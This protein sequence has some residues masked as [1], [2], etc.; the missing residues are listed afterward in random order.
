MSLVLDFVANFYEI[1]LSVWVYVLLG[2]LAAI[3][4]QLLIPKKK[5]V[6]ELGD[7]S[8]KSI[9]KASLA[10]IVLSA[11]SY[12]AVP[13]IAGL[14]KKGA[15]TANCLTMLLASPWFG[16]SQF[17]IL[18]GYVGFFNSIILLLTSLILSVIGGLIFKELGKRKLWNEKKRITRALLNSCNCSDV[19]SYLKRTDIGKELIELT[20]NTGKNLLITLLITALVKSV[21][22]PVDVIS[23]L[24]RS[25]AFSV[26]TA[27]P[28]ATLVEAIGEGLGIF[29]GELYSMGA[30]LGV[31]FTIIMVGVTT[32]VTELMMIN[33]IFGKKTSKY[34]V[35]V[36]TGLIV[37]ASYA[38][39]LLI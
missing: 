34:Y 26:L 4:I 35:L 23:V 30:G 12:G 17:V 21:L 29:A 8:L 14:R 39:N 16:L 7:N 11:C 37:I 24:G 15:T 3:L 10:G 1:I 18:T 20:V 32:D 19:D 6:K 38:L 22:T 2:L 13:I 31:V 33:S 25:N 28:L 5:I 9:I 27:V 36:S